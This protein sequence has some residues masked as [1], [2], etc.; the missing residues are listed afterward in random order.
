MFKQPV[1]ETRPK[2]ALKISKGD[3]IEEID[4]VLRD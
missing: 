1:I 4:R 3:F 2:D